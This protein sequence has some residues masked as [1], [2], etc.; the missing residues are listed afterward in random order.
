[1]RLDK[2][3]PG[4]IVAFLLSIVVAGCA[5]LEQ[6]AVFMT[7]PSNIPFAEAPQP[8][9]DS[10]LVYL[11]RIGINGGGWAPMVSVDGKPV[12]HFRL[13][14]YSAI[15]VKPGRHTVEFN[16]DAAG[17]FEVL[18]KETYYMGYELALKNPTIG[19]STSAGLFVVPVGP[20]IPRGPASLGWTVADESRVSTMHKVELKSRFYRRAATVDFLSPSDRLRYRSGTK[21]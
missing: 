9:A 6:T 14:E 21:P 11:Y 16:G 20:H 18:G 3:I 4:L 1:M 5:A 12:F 17:E 13:S 15:Y 8:E 10:A 2:Q 19:V 7:E